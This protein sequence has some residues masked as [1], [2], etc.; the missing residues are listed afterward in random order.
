MKNN[1]GMTIAEFIVSF[2]ILMVL[3]FSMMDTIIKIKDNNNDK[4]IQRE[5]LQYKT[6]LTK[7]ISNDLIEQGFDHVSNKNTSNNDTTIKL[8]FKDNSSKDL[9]IKSQDKVISYDGKNY[10]IPNNSYISP[11]TSFDVKEENNF[12]I[13]DIPIYKFDKQTDPTNYG[14]SIKFPY[15]LSFSNDSNITE[16]GDSGGQTQEETPEEP[17]E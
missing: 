15:K 4:E 8:I 3:V 5:L 7:I 10:P 17:E 13:I 9:V 12:L 2:V 16:G 1:K 14:I 6:T 11:V